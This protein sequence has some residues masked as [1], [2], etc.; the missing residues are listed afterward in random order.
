[1]K[2]ELRRHY[3]KLRE[4]QSEEKADR[5]SSVITNKLSELKN[6][7]DANCVMV[8]FAFRGEVD[9]EQLINFCIKQ[10]KCICMPKI[11]GD[12]IMEAVEYF[13]GCKMQKNTYG[14]LEP[15]GSKHIDKV[16]IDVVI[17]PAVAFDEKLFRLGYGG[18][19]YDRFLEGTD[20]TKIGVCFDFQITDELPSEKHDKRIDMVIS[21]K[22]TLGENG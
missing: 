2:S 8:Y 7:H 4:S 10:E 3:I 13:E 14:I 11:T 18:G 21:E 17:V 15:A 1:M 9:V 5:S 6:I 16:D 12:G 19:Y 22:R 20:V